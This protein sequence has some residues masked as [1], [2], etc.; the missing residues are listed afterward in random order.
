MIINDQSGYETIYSDEGS[1][2][3]D[4]AAMAMYAIGIKPLIDHLGSK[5]D[6]A[7][8]KQTWYADDSTSGGKILEM[9]KWWDELYVA[10]PKYG[11]FPKPS[12]TILIVKDPDLLQYAESIF[13]GTGINIVSEGDR[14]LGAVIGSIDY[15]RKYVEGKVGKWKRDVEQLSD[16]AKDEPQAALSAFTKALCMRWSFL[17]RTVPSSGDHFQ[18]L[19]DTIRE[20]LIPAIVGRKVSD[21]ERRLLALPVRLGGIGIQNPVQTAEYEYKS[22]CEI[23]ENLMSLIYNQELNLQ[24]YDNIKITAIINNLKAAKE[25]R[26][27]DEYVNIRS[28]INSDMK[29]SMDL[30]REKGSGAWLSALP[31]HSLGFV[32]NKQEFRDS[33]CL[34]YGWRIPN[35]PSFCSCGEK[36]NVDHTMNC[37]SGG[38]V[39]MRHNGIRDL[40]A[41]LLREVCKDV[42]VEPELLN[43][44]NVDLH[45]ANTAEKARL[46]VSAVGIW[47]PLERTFMDVRVMHPN[48]PSYKNKN[49][50]KVYTQHEQ[51]KKRMYN[52]RVL[53][54]EKGS[55]VPLVFSTTGG[56]GTECIKYH[57]R[58][59]ELISM[60][61]G[62]EYANVMNHIRTR[63]RFCL[64]RSALIAVRGVRGKQRQQKAAP[65]SE[66]SFNLIPDM[67]AYETN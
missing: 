33:L 54:I 62:E 15:R 25:R 41:E 18:P 47:S 12:K 4:V 36:N 30:A 50:E 55:F 24:K 29:R 7:K 65:I 23:T 49:I 16:I 57:K 2:Q 14:L 11:Y 37:K 19:E 38:Y 52:Q 39:I 8:C 59:A 56:M 3:G 26:L 43:I 34:R 28:E 22:S 35:T 40:E 58:V 1:T 48:S 44:G 9:R 5:V 46:D 20:K 63:I 21:L 60:K 13:N 42:K 66:L 51:E 67:P 31:I 53:Q 27:E 10:G 61:R 45:G 6:V 17:Q 64:L 32:L